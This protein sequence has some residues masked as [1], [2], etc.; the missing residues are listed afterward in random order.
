[1][2]YKL[3]GLLRTLG[4][5]ALTSVVAYLG[6]TSHLT[7]FVSVSV[8]TIVAGLAGILEHMIEENTG[9]ALFG[10]VRV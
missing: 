10:A 9:R 3:V 7:P 8:A 1:M 4:V 2:N 5:I 6:D